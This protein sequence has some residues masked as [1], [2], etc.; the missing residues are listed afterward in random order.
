[1]PTEMFQIDSLVITTPP[2][3]NWEAD[4]H[5][6]GTVPVIMN[7]NSFSKCNSETTKTESTVLTKLDLFFN[8]P[9]M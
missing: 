8:S 9:K 5:N 7:S 1:M 3:S 4:E 2:L 6:I